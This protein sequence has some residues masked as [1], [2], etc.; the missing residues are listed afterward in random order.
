MN[1]ATASDKGLLR[2]QEAVQYIDLRRYRE[3]GLLGQFVERYWSVRW[4]LP[5]GTS[6]ES[7][8]I[9]HPCVNL[10]FMPVIGAELHGP[11]IAVSRHHLTGRGRVFGVKFRPGGFTAYSGVEGAALADWS[12]GAA[13]VFGREVDELNSI[14]MSGSDIDAIQM[15][16]RFLTDRVPER[17]DPRYGRVLAVVRAMLEDRSITR[18]DQVAARFAMSPKTLQRLFQDYLGLGPKTLIQRYRL[19]DAADRLAEDPESDLARLAAEL[20]WSDHAHFTHDFKN[21]I[22][23]PPSEYAAQCATAGRELVLAR[24]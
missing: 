1:G 18:V 12:A 21:L 2:P 4:D 20:G 11:G 7:V 24:R 5:E 23:F 8:V 19:H 9:P 10:S 16:S 6:Y 13:T 15:V 14:V 3:T 17:P 22:G